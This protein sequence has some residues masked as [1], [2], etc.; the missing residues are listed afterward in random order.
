MPISG[1]SAPD[2]PPEADLHR[3]VTFAFGGTFA[4][5][6]ADRAVQIF[7]TAILARA[8]T[9]ADFGVVTAAMVFVSFLTLISQMGIGAALVQSPQLTQRALSAGLVSVV[10]A[11]VLAILTAQ[12]AAPFIGGWFRNPDVT[13]VVRVLSLNCLIQALTV[14]PNVTLMRGLRARSISLIEL[15]ASALG[16]GAVAIP[17]ALAGWG[18][19]AL[20]AGAM[21][22]TATRTGLFWALAKPRTNLDF[23]L[24]DVTGLWRK[25]SGFFL[26]NVLNKAASESDRWV[27]GR[28]LTTTGLGL[29]SKASGLMTFPARLYGAVLDRVAFPAFAKV[30]NEAERMGRAYSDALSLTAVVGLPLSVLLAFTA[31]QAILLVL[32][33]QWIGAIDPFKILSLAIY[34]RLADK[35]NAALLKGAGRPSLVSAAHALYGVVVFFGGLWAVRY[36]LEAVAWMVAVAALLTNMLLTFLAMRIARLSLWRLLPAHAPGVASAILAACTLAPAVWV[37]ERFALAPFTS[38]AVAGLSLGMVGLAVIA[39]APRIFLGEP[40]MRVVEVV[41]PRLTRLAWRG[42]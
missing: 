13:N 31:P 22:Q 28:H 10:G 3:K 40:G 19:W 37:A 34:F 1:S 11:A 4:I 38:L 5:V 15:M 33:P 2:Q 29:Y 26:S 24:S 9:P 16:S 39:L 8:L 35:V 17:M 23:G 12:A 18:Y 27:V 25:G 21:V 41:V 6:M 20:V 42:R 7:I 32:G 30:Q 36:G 14:I